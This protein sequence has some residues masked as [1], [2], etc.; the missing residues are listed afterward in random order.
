MSL[1][2]VN[3]DLSDAKHSLTDLHIMLTLK[4]SFSTAISKLGAY[5]LYIPLLIISVTFYER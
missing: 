3:P 1:F 4:K 2:F 5:H